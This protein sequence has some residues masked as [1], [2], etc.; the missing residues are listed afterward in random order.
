MNPRDPNNTRTV[1]FAHTLE[2]RPPEEWEPLED[3][4]RLVAGGNDQFPGAAGFAAEF[5]AADWGRLMGLWHDLGKYSAEFQAYLRM[6][7]DADVDSRRGSVDHSTAG[8]QHAAMRFR[9]LTGKLLAYCVAGHHGGLPDNIDARGGE[10]GLA[11]RLTKSICDY[12]VAP[13]ELLD[14]PQPAKP[15]MDWN[16]SERSR[17]FQASVF[18]RMLFSCL[19]DA[20]FLAT[21]FFMR[22]D[23]SAERPS[24]QPTPADLLPHL[25]SHLDQLQSQSRNT[26]V[27]LARA[28]I[29]SQCREKADLPPGFFSLTVPTGGGKTLSSLAFALRH[30][31]RHGLH[32]VIY[33][34][35]FTSIIEQNAR[36]FRE[37]L[38]NAG[39]EVVLEHHS[40][41]EPS[42]PADGTDHEAQTPWYRLTAENWDAPLVVTTNVQLFE[43]LFASKPSRC[44]KLHRI[45]RSVIILDECQTLPVTLLEPTLQIL[46]ELCRNYGCTVVLCSATQPAVQHRNDF[47]IGLTGVREIVNDPPQLYESLRRVE[48]TRLGKLD[49]GAIIERL[50]EHEQVLCVV[51]TRAHAARLF[52]SL[53][54]LFGDDSVFHLSA[55]MCAAHRTRVLDQIRNRIDP[56]KPQP[57]RVISTQLIEA[58]VDVDF[59][60]VYRAMTGLDA[61]AQA[62]GRCNR[63]GRLDRGH[64]YIFDTD[65]DPRGDLRLRRDKGAEV[66]SL[67][68]D[69]MGLAAIDHYFR[70]IYWSQSGER[71]K[72]D[73]A[74]VLKCFSLNRDGPHFQFREAAEKYRLIR[75][76][77]QPIIVPYRKCGRELVR[78]LRRLTESPG[79][80]FDRRAQ[81]YSV[82][83]YDRQFNQLR[84]NHAIAQYHERFWVLEND[85]AYDEFVG[86]R[87]D[88]VGFDPAQLYI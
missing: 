46:A 31:A 80:G 67:H 65:V 19:V 2:G 14:Q 84:E 57:C 6:A 66:A 85:S 13:T 49:D 82:G 60:V 7:G 71:N 86:L 68:P 33:A 4:L 63:E 78:R 32:R 18:C 8:A 24:D 36:V 79:R 29:L 48:V 37:A 20:D 26:R 30:A 61:I 23:R 52:T 51:N 69:V 44:R 40:N 16:R 35:P 72:W 22:H 41:F 58:G 39:D 59:P 34:I 45:A 38:A 62:A 1:P 55:Q 88:A 70:L 81:R 10:S 47:C 27:N 74:G 77:Q 11:N 73:D 87:T 12:S 25:D 54:D 21:E 83:L 50:R 3:H 17:A 43:S 9:S 64:V 53:Y 56:R 5:G 28:Q 42:E 76:A 75:D 15:N